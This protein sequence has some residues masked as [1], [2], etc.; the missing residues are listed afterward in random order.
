VT[1]RFGNLVALVGLGISLVAVGCG[2]E[3]DDGPPTYP[4]KGQIIVKNGDVKS[5]VGGY[6]R[7]VS[8][9]DNKIIGM[10]EIQ[11]DGTFGVG[12]FVD[13]KP[14]DGLQEGEYRA[15]VEPRGFDQQDSDD[16]PPPARK[17]G[18]LPKY[19]AYET[20]GLK[21]AIKPGENAITVEVEAR[22]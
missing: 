22:R 11:D 8:M 15:R 16:Q 4:V 13:G 12:T 14:R 7:L 1:S 19:Q 3:K 5:L 21:Y 2:G 17:G 6:V 9:A 10:G 20:S 18:L